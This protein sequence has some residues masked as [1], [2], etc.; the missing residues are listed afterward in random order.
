MAPSTAQRRAPRRLGL[1]PVPKAEAPPQGRGP[2][3]LPIRTAGP[4]SRGATHQVRGF[5][6]ACARPQPPELQLPGAAC[7]KGAEVPGARPD[8]RILS[9]RLLGLLLQPPGGLRGAR[10]PGPPSRTWSRSGQLL[11]PDHGHR[12]TVDRL[13]G[14]R[15]TRHRVRRRRR[16]LAAAVQQVH[17]P[18]GRGRLAALRGP[19]ASS[20]AGCRDARLRRRAGQVQSPSG[21]GAAPTPPAR[22][23]ARA[24][25]AGT[26]PLESARPRA[27]RPDCRGPHPESRAMR[28]RVGAQARNPPR[29]QVRPGCAKPAAGSSARGF[30]V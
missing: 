18:R 8:L 5:R 4:L 29:R 30:I 22:S 19:A 17:V 24:Q 23:E 21:Q 3:L 11:L 13:P 16:G 9:R 15:P 26:A 20:A 2:C 6:V 10:G 7:A 1:A 27:T 28:G 12:D 25:A 14:G